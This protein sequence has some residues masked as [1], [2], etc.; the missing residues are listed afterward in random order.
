MSSARPY[1]DHE[2]ADELI[3]GRCRFAADR[4]RSLDPL[5]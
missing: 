2:L 3:G 5:Q 1:L 4:Q